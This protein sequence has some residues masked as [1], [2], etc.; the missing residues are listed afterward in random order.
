KAQQRGLKPIPALYQA[1]DAVLDIQTDKLA[2]PRRFTAVM[3]EIWALQPRFEQRSGRRPFALM[4]HER[5]RAGYDFLVLRAASGE[6]PA[7]LA[8]WWEKFQHAREDERNAMLLA[9][10]PD[11]HR[12]RRRR[13]RRKAAPLPPDA[14][15]A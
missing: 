8:Q 2:I 14:A 7:E 5:F 12:R 3:K 13:R 1:M 6:A 4:T 9:P 11:E 10:Q 15:P